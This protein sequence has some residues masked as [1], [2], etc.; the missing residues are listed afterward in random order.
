MD[1][2]YRKSQFLDVLRGIMRYLELKMRVLSVEEMSKICRHGRWSNKG[3]VAVVFPLA[4]RGR[5]SA[6]W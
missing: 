6:D 5:A 2:I 3:T 4:N 1:P